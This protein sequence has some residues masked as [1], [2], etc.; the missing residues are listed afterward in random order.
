MGPEDSI[1]V[2]DY[3]AASALTQACAVP[4][5]LKFPELTLRA[6]AG[7]GTPCRSPIRLT[8]PVICRTAEDDFRCEY[9]WCDL[10]RRCGA[11]LQDTHEPFHR[12]ER[13]SPSRIERPKEN[14]F[15][16][17]RACPAGAG[18]R[19][20]NM[21]LAA[22]PHCGEYLPDLLLKPRAS[23]RRRKGGYTDQALSPHKRN[24]EHYS[25][26]VSRVPQL[27]LFY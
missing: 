21:G 25:G 4:R 8:G 11:P 24:P 13:T 6:L 15:Q 7:L 16:K 12:R 23:R 2:G 1:G 20:R 26:F 18:G 10:L 9:L 19:S 17:A 27:R 22:L 14:K 3:V 5:S